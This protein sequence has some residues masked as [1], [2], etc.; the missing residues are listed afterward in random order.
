MQYLT[1]QVYAFSVTV[2]T[3]FLLGVFFDIY[4]VMQG[5]IR[6][7]KIITHLGDLLFWIIS[8]GFIFLLLLFGNWG[9]FRLYVFLGIGLGVLIYLR[10]FSRLTIK[11]L[12]AIIKTINYLNNLIISFIRYII[13]AVLFPLRV[14]KNIIII[15][16]GFV[17]TV[18]QSGQRLLSCTFRRLL[19][20]P[21]KKSQHWIKTKLGKF[22]SVFRNL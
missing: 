11:L 21:V 22:F 3:G 5:V 19:G 8:T 2:L 7:R 14:I 16:I 18:L 1:S 17:G 13:I 4:R 12:L 15:P 6:P 10:W 9:D 20:A